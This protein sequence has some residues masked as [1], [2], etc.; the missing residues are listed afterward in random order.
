MSGNPLFS[1]WYADPEAVIFKNEYWIYPTYSARY[2]EQVFVDAF[3]SIDLV[4]W[5]KHAKVL[6]TANVKWAKRAMWAPA[7]VEKDGKYY[8][9]FASNYIQS[10]NE[11]G[12]IGVA[13][14][15]KPQGPFKD[16]LGKPLIDK[17]YN[18][19]QPIDQ[20]VLKTSMDLITFSMVDGSIVILPS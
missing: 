11:Y 6:D 9:F 19:A 20:F 15:D 18:K 1:G 4:K 10:D 5:K 14:A 3:S 7:S 2:E 17:F 8:L 16:F 13:I 12:G